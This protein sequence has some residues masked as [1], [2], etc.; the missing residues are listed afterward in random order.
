MKRIKLKIEQHE[1]RLV[2]KTAVEY[3]NKIISKE[4]YSDVVDDALL[5]AC[6]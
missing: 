1:L 3:R 4:D 5:K 6:N 2:I